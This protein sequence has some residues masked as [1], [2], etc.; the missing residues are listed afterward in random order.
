MLRKLLVSLAACFASCWPVRT[1]A[2]GPS[3]GSNLRGECLRRHVRLARDPDRVELAFLVEELLRGGQ[4]EDRERRAAERA[5]AAEL[6]EPRDP[7]FLHRAT[8]EHADRVSD[9]EVLRRGGLCV[10]RDLL[11]TV[12]P[13]PFGE[14]KRIEALVAGRVDAEGETRRAAARDDLVVAIDE[15]RLVGDAALGESDVGQCAHFSE[16]RFRQR[17]RR[18]AV[19]L[20]AA[21]RALARDDGVGVLVDLRE[22]G[23]ERGLDR[24]GQHVRAAD[25]RDTE[26]HRHCRQRGAQ[27]PAEQAFEGDPDHELRL[28]ITSSTS[29]AVAPR[30]SWTIKPSARNRTRSAITAARGSCVTI[31]IVWP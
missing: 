7:E 29:A 23:P 3:R 22:D 2:V 6:H 11:G 9:L 31:T 5:H 15:L 18:D 27:L 20:V 25:H 19:V 12:R 1:C 16:Q 21:D 8:R 17:R 4:V 30:R 28:L 24:V 10:D 13:L 14:G 26:H